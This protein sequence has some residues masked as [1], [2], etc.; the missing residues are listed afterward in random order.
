MSRT[1]L[2]LSAVLIG[3]LL[4]GCDGGLFGTGD[5]TDVADASTIPDLASPG[6]S[7]PE[8]SDNPS[9]ANPDAGPEAP[10]INIPTDTDDQLNIIGF[11]N[12]TPSGINSLSATVPA[13]KLINLTERAV[14]LATVEAQSITDTLGVSP[15]STSELL[16]VNTGES[17]VSVRTTENDIET[18]LVSINPLNAVEDSITTLVI[19][20]IKVSSDDAQ[21]TSGFNVSVLA[22]DTRAV[23]SANTMAEVR[24]VTL[25]TAD[26]DSLPPSYTLSPDDVNS[27]GTELELFTADDDNPTATMYSLAN[28]GSYVLNSTDETFT[29]EPIV[30]IED[31]VYT[32]IITGNPQAPIYVEVDS[33]SDVE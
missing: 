16:D 21:Q 20:S 11:S 26:T 30:L 22:L 27:S 3:L 18:T 25:R 15:L 33:V 10:S 2:L 8:P 17:V 5:S 31:V 4:S 13:L 14:T 24:I 6:N 12:T 1:R 32:I 28:A 9:V 19:K 7:E 23:A 29:P